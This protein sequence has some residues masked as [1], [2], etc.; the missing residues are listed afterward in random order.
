MR[1]VLR[2]QAV[3]DP[4]VSPRRVHYWEARP[5][6]FTLRIYPVGGFITVRQRYLVAERQGRAVLSQVRF[7]RF[8]EA[9]RWAE[10]FCGSG[11]VLRADM[12]RPTY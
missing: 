11:A 3:Y 4:G 2:W 5:G 9:R 10:D 8:A 7:D 6:Q 1:A 12:L